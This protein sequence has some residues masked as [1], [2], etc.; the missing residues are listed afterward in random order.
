MKRLIPLILLTSFLQAMEQCAGPSTMNSSDQK[1]VVAMNAQESLKSS[2]YVMTILQ[3]YV[4]DGSHDHLIMARKSIQEQ[5]NVF[6]LKKSDKWLGLSLFQIQA[7]CNLGNLIHLTLSQQELEALPEEICLLNHLTE[8]DVSDNELHSLP[9]SIGNMAQ[10][11][12]LKAND[13]KL[14]KLPDNMNC[15][16]L[17]SLD[18]GSNK[19]RILPE[20]KLTSLQELYVG[21]N[22]ISKLP[23]LKS[24]RLLTRLEVCNNP[25]QNL[26]QMIC[27]LTALKKLEASSVGFWLQAIP[28]EISKL[29]NLEQLD[30]SNNRISDVPPSISSLKKLQQ[31][32]LGRNGIRWLPQEIQYL[33][34]LQELNIVP[35]SLEKEQK[36]QIERWFPNATLH[37]ASQ[38]YSFMASFGGPDDQC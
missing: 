9:S 15:T 10:L 7:I 2:E 21:K 4:E 32:L 11:Q 27:G 8:L 37:L 23:D 20:I 38:E 30:L 29:T 34:S 17:Q 3:V 26:F 22:I 14:K 13:N 19:F 28:D 25:I 18:I 24:I 6:Y 35:N 5:R 36:K 12:I 16:S 33:T 31:L 1:P